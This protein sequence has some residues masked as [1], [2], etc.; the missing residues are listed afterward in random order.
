M[1]NMIDY[2]K[3]NHKTM[4]NS[5]LNEVDSL[6]LSQLAYIRYYPP[7]GGMYL[8]EIYANEVLYE[9]S[10]DKKEDQRNL[11][12][13]EAVSLS[14]RF[15]NIRLDNY[16]EITNEMND[17][18]FAAMTFYLETGS[19]YVAYRGT[20][21]TLVGWREDFNMAFVYPIPAQKT[22]LAYLSEIGSKN[23][24][25][26]Y[27]GGHSKGGNLAIYASC[28]VSEKIKKNIIFVFSHDGPGF[29]QEFLE[30]CYFNT[31]KEKLKKTVPESSL[32][33]MLLYTHMHYTIIKSN[34]FFIMQH[35]PFSWV[36]EEDHFVEV[37]KLS[38]GSIYTN[39]VIYH[40]LKNLP[41]EKREH[42]INALFN[43]LAASG[44]KTF[45]EFSYVWR[46]KIP[47]MLLAMSDL[48]KEEKYYL[49]E[50]IKA[51]LVMAIKKIPGALG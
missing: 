20:D 29:Q 40:W 39:E 5:P 43:I 25:P 27:V 15:K 47:A 12:L 50:T 24:N 28:L 17:E 36:V 42:F 44:A 9:L 51:L 32:I 31:I 22:A 46:Q 38:N 33:G 23:S 48:S 45:K 34:E 1:A 3:Q 19:I 35:D 41:K 14:L 10:K 16:K 37:E 6:V 18:Q 8:R 4:M 26:I 49:W 13:L 21:G 30:Q 11:A 7:V 2:V